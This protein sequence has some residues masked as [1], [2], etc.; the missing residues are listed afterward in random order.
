MSLSIVFVL[1]VPFKSFKLRSLVY[2]VFACAC[3]EAP[4][5]CSLRGLV[6]FAATFDFYPISKLV[7][8]LEGL[9]NSGFPNVC[10]IV[11]FSLE[12]F[13]KTFI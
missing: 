1:C 9:P 4:Q 2:M 8:K 13:Q 5:P 7:W 10:L 3:F 6:D 12:F 11:G